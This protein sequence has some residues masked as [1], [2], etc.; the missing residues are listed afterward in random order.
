M[1]PSDW[2]ADGHWLVFRPDV[3]GRSY[4][5]RIFYRASTAI[6]QLGKNKPV[7]LLIHGFPTSSWD[8]HDVWDGLAQHYDLLAADMLGFGCSDKPAAFPYCIA[9]QADIQE[10]LVRHLGIEQ[11]HILAHDYGDTVTQELMARQ[12]EQS[13]QCFQSVTL[14]NGGLF[15]EAHRPLWSQRLLASPLGSWFARGITEKKLARGLQRI[16]Q[17][18]LSGD[19]LSASWRFLSY[20]HGPRVLPRLMGYMKERRQQR[21]RWVGALKDWPHR[22]HLING[23][24]DPISGAHMVARYRQVLERDDITELADVG[25]YPQLEAPQ[26]IVKVMTDAGL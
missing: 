14:L 17:Q 21:Q 7:L 9:V 13:Q 12:L 6:S 22:L 24:A 25:H 5:L 23:S 11:C 4:D 1:T 18:P 2:Q 15:P 20:R 16:C 3:D 8:W 19:D 26:V 10:A